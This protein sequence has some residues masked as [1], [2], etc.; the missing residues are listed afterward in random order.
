MKPETPSK[1]LKSV[2]IFPSKKIHQPQLMINGS[3]PAVEAAE[4]KLITLVERIRG[5][6]TAKARWGSPTGP[7]GIFFEDGAVNWV[8][9]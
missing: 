6:A 2:M 8:Q 5:A 1:D 7:S 9:P 3:S 4:A